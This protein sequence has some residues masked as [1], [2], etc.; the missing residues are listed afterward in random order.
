[1]AHQAQGEGTAPRRR[2]LY[3]V[4]ICTL[5]AGCVAVVVGFVAPWYDVTITSFG[6]SREQSISPWSL[7]AQSSGRDR[8]LLLVFL[9]VPGVLLIG[10]SLSLLFARRYS[11]EAVL[12]AVFLGMYL[13]LL[14]VMCV[15]LALPSLR[16][17]MSLRFREYGAWVA[18][19]GVLAIGLG[20]S[21]VARA[22]SSRAST[23]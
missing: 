11:T 9:V 8:L 7:V 20:A 1:M 5:I 19:I 18:F 17:N 14:L 13:C 12:L 15:L 16:G 4:G 6:V 10:S 21:W 23:P 22:P 3:R 2:W